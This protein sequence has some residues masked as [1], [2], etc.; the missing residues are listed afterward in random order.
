MISCLTKI[1][2]SG[3]TRPPSHS[4]DF[5]SDQNKVLRQNTSSQ[6][7]SWFPVWPNWST[8]AE[9]VLPVTVMISC[10]TKIKYSGRTRPPS[11][12]HDFLSDQNKVLRQNTSSQSQ[13][14]FP[15]WPNWST[16]AE[17][18]LSQNQEFSVGPISNWGLQGFRRLMFTHW[19]ITQSASCT[20]RLS[21][22][23]CYVQNRNPC[24]SK[25]VCTLCA[26]KNGVS[27]CCAVLT[28]TLSLTFANIEMKLHRTIVHTL[29]YMSGVKQRKKKNKN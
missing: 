6:S 13:S 10:L 2:Y 7:Q 15:V 28:L 20:Q 3:R 4:H 26:K 8:Q 5:L 29:H 18:V 21:T 12:S 24:T 11:H 16:Q 1:K 27:S 9:H 23:Q 25:G 19:M 14:W 17:H 22:T